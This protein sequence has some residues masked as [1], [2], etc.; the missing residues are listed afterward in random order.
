MEIFKITKPDNEIEYIEELNIP[1]LEKEPLSIENV[2]YLSIEVDQTLRSKKRL[3]QLI[4]EERDSVEL[5]SKEKEPLQ[6]EYVDELFIE[7]A[8]KPENEIQLIDQ[9][10][11]LKKQS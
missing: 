8:A 9:M 4:V 5:L 2:D 1:R 11:I 3:A 10:E 7:K 6:T